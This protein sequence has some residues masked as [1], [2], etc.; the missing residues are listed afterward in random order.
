MADL[1]RLEL[2]IK[3]SLVGAMVGDALGYPWSFGNQIIPEELHMIKGPGDELPGEYTSLSGT[4]LCTIDSLLECDGFDENDLLD[5]YYELFVG[6]YLTSHGNC[7]DTGNTISQAI[8]N[9]SNGLPVDRTGLGDENS[10]DGDC[11]PR[12][13]PLALYFANED[14]P[15]F[16][17]V[18]ER[19][20]QITHRHLRSVVTS[21]AYAVIIRNLTR[22]QPGKVFDQLHTHW[23]TI[24]MTD[25]V[26][27]L[28]HL[29]SWNN[30]NSCSGTS[31]I[32]DAY[33]TSWKSFASFQGSYTWSV[34]RAIQHGNDCN[35]TGFI[36]GSLGGLTNGLNDIPSEWLRDIKL[37]SEVMGLVLRFMP[38]ILRKIG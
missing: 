2:F 5:R 32:E 1:E 23:S 37:S 9:F 31:E 10:N 22:Q 25:H 17:S 14:L 13:L 12:M 24:G 18:I 4:M 8:D 30:R 29:K 19:A 20:C 27:T 36:T 35:L 6:G 26:K 15:Q 38:V 21:S 16:L 7:Y 33:W 11:L 34:T 28:E 3:G